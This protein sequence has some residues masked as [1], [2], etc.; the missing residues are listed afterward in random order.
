MVMVKFITISSYCHFEYSVT[1]VL[2]GLQMFHMNS[3]NG[4][5]KDLPEQ[6]KNSSLGNHL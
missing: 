6:K 2:H 5:I 3:L 4:Y 1:D